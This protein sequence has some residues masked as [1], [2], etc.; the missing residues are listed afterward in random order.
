[1]RNSPSVDR[2]MDK[3]FKS[4]Q[5]DDQTIRD[6]VNL[7]DNISKLYTVEDLPL[8]TI[9]HTYPYIQSTIHATLKNVEVKITDDSGFI[10]RLFLFDNKKTF[11]IV[12][13]I[14]QQTSFETRL[15]LLLNEHLAQYQN[16]NYHVRGVTPEM[17]TI[18]N[19]IVRERLCQS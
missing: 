6:I 5:P 4:D 11:Q 19:E 18:V 1:M 13:V 9:H 7:G 17:A 8:L 10:D 15:I 2:V 14:S 3:D 16:S 12:R